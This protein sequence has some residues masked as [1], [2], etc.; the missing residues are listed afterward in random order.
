MEIARLLVG[1]V[2]RAD[3]QIL[4]H[5]TRCCIWVRWDC[6]DILGVKCAYHVERLSIQLMVLV[7]APFMVCS[8][9]PGD[10]VRRSIRA[11]WS[12]EAFGRYVKNAVTAKLWELVD[13]KSWRRHWL[14]GNN[15]L[16]KIFAV[17]DPEEIGNQLWAGV[18]SPT[19]W[20]DL[21]M[22]DMRT[23]SVGRWNVATYFWRFYPLIPV[24]H[25]LTLIFM[26][27]I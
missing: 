19:N 4:R 14:T 23:R 11:L 3:R 20:E 12:V 16:T 6:R 1:I 26:V 8:S 18:D 27:G 17:A 15:W 2:C 13:L 9:T 22:H 10:Y 5:C 24:E 21:F 25:R 7:T